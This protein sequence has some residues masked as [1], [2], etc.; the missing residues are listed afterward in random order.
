[1]V[2]ISCVKIN[3]GLILINR[4]RVILCFK[5]RILIDILGVEVLKLWYKFIFEY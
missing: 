3:L 4:E 5:Y 1:M 2:L